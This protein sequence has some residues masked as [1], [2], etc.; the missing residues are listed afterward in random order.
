MI[1]AHVYN[2]SVTQLYYVLILTNLK[3]LHPVHERKLDQLKY[4]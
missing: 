1:L 4:E 2:Q 3:Q